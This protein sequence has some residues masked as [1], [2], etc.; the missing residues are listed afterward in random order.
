MYVVLE[1]QYQSSMTVACK[2]INAAQPNLCVEAVGYL[3]EELRN[4]ATYEKFKKD[5]ETANMFIGS[6]I[7]V[8]ELAEKVVDVVKPLRDKLDAVLIFPS[9]PDVMRLNKVGSFTMAQMGQSQS[10]IGEFMKKKRQEA[11][12]SFEGSM[13]KLLRTLPKVLKYLPSDKAQDARS[14]MLSFQY[15]LGGSPENLESLLLLMAN[16]Y[17]YEKSVTEEI[18]APVGHSAMLFLS[19]AECLSSFGLVYLHVLHEYCGRHAKLLFQ[20]ECI[21]Y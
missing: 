11:G 19:P 5:V 7:F 1:S 4:P 14:F 13:L 10:V 9:M 16:T 21:R 15:W 20:L 17:I 12:A 6:L 2:R 18:A 8:Q 3:L